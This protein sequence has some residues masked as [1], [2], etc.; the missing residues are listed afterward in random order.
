M[1]V[2]KALGRAR[3]SLDGL[4]LGDALGKTWSTWDGAAASLLSSP[5]RV[6]PAPWR[7]TDD[8]VMS[9][10][11]VEIIERHGAIDPDRLAAEFAARFRAEPERGYGGGRLLASLPAGRRR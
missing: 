5:L 11:I 6:P 8:T 3:D 2:N 1:L 4:S 7:Y 9:M 10:A